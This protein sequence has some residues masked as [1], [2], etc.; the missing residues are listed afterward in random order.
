VILNYSPAEGDKQVFPFKPEKLM[1]VEA[2]ILE[3]ITDW[4]FAEFQ[5]KLISGS[6]R[7]RR[8]MLWILQKRQHPTLRL[9]DVQPL[10]GE[11][12]LEF[13]REELLNMRDAA[14]ASRQGS[15]QDRE[16]VIALV[17]QLLEA[18]SDDT[19]P[20]APVSDAESS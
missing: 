10:V 2:E 14:E 7:A 11:V 16:N 20:K 18:S 17:N 1:S 8:C 9:D 3:R 19:A 13:E 4:T 15:E 6:A 12:E 5:M